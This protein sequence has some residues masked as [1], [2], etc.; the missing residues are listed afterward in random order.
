MLKRLKAVFRLG[1]FTGNTFSY[2]STKAQIDRALL[3]FQQLQEQRRFLEEHMKP[4]YSD[5]QYQSSLS[6]IEAD[7]R[8]LLKKLKGYFTRISEIGPT[9][10]RQ[11]LEPR[12]LATHCTGGNPEETSSWK[13]RER[14]AKIQTESV[15]SVRRRLELLLPDDD[16]DDVRKS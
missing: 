13:P 6:R 3:E 1:A 15:E 5:V 7:Q 4:W 10:G 8:R 16:S 14:E 9:A 11:G 12:S 2:E